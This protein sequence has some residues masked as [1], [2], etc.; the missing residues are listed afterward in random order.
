MLKKGGKKELEM[1]AWTVDV[2]QYKNTV[3]AVDKEGLRFYF[4]WNNRM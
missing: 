3:Q 4:M 1:K 2:P